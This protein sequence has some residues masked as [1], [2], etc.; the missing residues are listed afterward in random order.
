MVSVRI[1]DS[2]ARTGG[3]ARES[4]GDELGMQTARGYYRS[5]RDWKQCL[6]G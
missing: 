4:C 2:Q 1:G 5:A 3:T 6:G